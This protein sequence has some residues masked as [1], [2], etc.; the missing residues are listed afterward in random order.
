VLASRCD[1]DR[2]AGWPGLARDEKEE[3]LPGDGA[4]DTLTH[5]SALD[6]S[7]FSAES[8]SLSSSDSS[9]SLLAFIETEV[10]V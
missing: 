8:K 1:L 9:D 10:D 3:H 4:P 6:D 5:A 2:R 7:G